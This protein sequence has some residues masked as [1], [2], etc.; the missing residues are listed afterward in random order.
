MDL[1][2]AIQSLDV[3]NNKHWTSD[4]LPR[5]DVLSEVTA[6][7]V[8]RELV[9]EV[10]FGFT[11][12]N[13]TINSTVT[14]TN[15]VAEIITKKTTAENQNE[16]ELLMVEISKLEDVNINLVAQQVTLQDKIK[17]NE[18]IISSLR[19]KLSNEDDPHKLSNSLQLLFA[20]SDRDRRLFEEKQNFILKS[21]VD[22][23]V[24]TSGF[25]PLDVARVS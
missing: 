6:S 17:A 9:K 20:A 25:N 24:L 21:G 14:E 10:A 11:R 12:T 3:N 16:D 15:P 13:T 5:L 2:T 18:E 19:L 23:S 22:L 7:Q 4:G 8:T 1:L